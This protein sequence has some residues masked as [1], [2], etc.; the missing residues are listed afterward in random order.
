MH[1]SADGHLG[2]SHVLAAV[3]SAAVNTGVHVSLSVMVSSGSVPSSGTVGLYG[4]FIPGVLRNLHT[5]LHRFA[6]PPTVQEHTPSLVFIVCRIF[7]DSHSDLCEVIPHCSFD[8]HSS[9]NEGCSAFFHVFAGH[10]Y[11]FF[12]EKSV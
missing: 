5:L 3:N 6:F 7:D 11:I 12:G 10:L 1:S 4:S 8:V 2:C 9:T